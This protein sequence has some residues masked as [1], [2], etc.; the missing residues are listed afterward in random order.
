MADWFNDDPFDS[1]FEEFFGG[2]RPGFRKREKFII[3]EDEERVIDVI[4]TGDKAYLIFELPGYNEED[5]SIDIR[6]RTIEISIEKRNV[7][8][9]KEYLAQK[10]SAGLRY[11]RKLP[12]SIN[13]KNFEYTLKN[14]ILEIKFD[15]A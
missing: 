1:I 8:G 5:V 13:P 7:E 14:G 9:I 15:K 6:G 4:D 3:G 10:L 12:D 2:S 11:T